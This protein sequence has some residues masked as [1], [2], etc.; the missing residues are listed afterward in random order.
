MLVSAGND[1]CLVVYLKYVSTHSGIEVEVTPV[2][3]IEGEE[4]SIQCTV[5]E[6]RI[7]ELTGK[8]AWSRAGDELIEVHVVDVRTKRS[9]DFQVLVHIINGFHCKTEH[10]LR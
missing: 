10:I 5:I 6:N 4:L 8:D 2:V 3:V 7:G 1:G 9:L